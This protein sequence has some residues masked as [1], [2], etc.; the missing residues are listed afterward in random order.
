MQHAVEHNNY[1]KYLKYIPLV[2]IL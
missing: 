1:N 2:C